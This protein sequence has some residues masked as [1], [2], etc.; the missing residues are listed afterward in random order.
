MKQFKIIAL[1]AIVVV[2]SAFIV[3]TK[4]ETSKSAVGTYGVIGD[5]PTLQL[6]I[7]DDQTFQY[8]DE[9]TP[10]IKIDVI[11]K[12]SQK[13]NNIMLEN[14]KSEHKIP[15]KWKLHKDQPCVK[16]KQGL[17]FIRICDC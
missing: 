9:T 12:W 3:P 4:K 1:L 7:L 15:N 16:A 10:G 2:T 8:I 14:Y 13:D 5:H 6:K 17:K 11:G